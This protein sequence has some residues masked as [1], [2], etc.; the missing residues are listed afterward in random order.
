MKLKYFESEAEFIRKNGIMIHIAGRS[1]I[2]KSDHP[3]EDPIKI[4]S[5]DIHIQ[6]NRSVYEYHENVILSL[7]EIIQRL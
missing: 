4:H 1:N 5:E 3:S 6:N 2:I 7:N